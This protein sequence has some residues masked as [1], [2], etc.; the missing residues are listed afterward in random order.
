VAELILR[1]FKSWRG[2]L[3]SIMI[4]TLIDLGIK[5]FGPLHK[6]S[7]PQH[8]QA[9]LVL[10]SSEMTR[11]GLKRGAVSQ[12]E[13]GRPS[14]VRAGATDGCRGGIWGED[15]LNQGTNEAT[16]E[17]EVMAEVEEYEEPS[18]IS[19]LSDYSKDQLLELV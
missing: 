9:V 6:E 3:L 2:K 5:A 1:Q 14:Q 4:A 15:Y 12:E 13:S 10:P 17:A 18:M 11:S 7:V 16:S 8:S 19:E